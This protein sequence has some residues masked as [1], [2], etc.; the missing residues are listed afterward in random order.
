MMQIRKLFYGCSIFTHTLLPRT[1]ENEAMVRECL[2]SLLQRIHRAMGSVRYSIFWGTLLGAIRE[3]G[4]IPHDDDIDLAVH[5]DDWPTFLRDVLPQLSQVECKNDAWYQVHCQHPQGASE[6]LHADIVRAD[7]KEGTWQDST[8][9]FSLPLCT[10]HLGGVECSGPER[11]L[12]EAYLRQS[13]GPDWRTPRC[14]DVQARRALYVVVGVL[15]CI[16]LAARHRSYAG[17]ALALVVVLA[18]LWFALTVH[19]RSHPG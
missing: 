12:A 16:I 9:L 13:Y 1:P 8:F 15:I 19:A 18:L 4:F 17:T 11:S 2:T 3:D 7:Y 5:P 14:G 10:Y 6:S